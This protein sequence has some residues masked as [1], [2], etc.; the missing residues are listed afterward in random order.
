MR[1]VQFGPL[2]ELP[3]Q[4]R[5]LL[6]Q[7]NEPNATTGMPS[8]MEIIRASEFIRVGRRG[9]PDMKAS[10]RLLAELAEASRQRGIYRVLLDLREVQVGAV[11]A[12]TPVE[13]AS[14]IDTFRE[15]G[16]ASEQRVAVL[17][18]VDP[19]HGAR[20]FAFLSRQRGW[21]VKAF[22]NYEQAI[23]WLVYTTEPLPKAA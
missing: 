14:L 18:A 12:C 5:S 4:T 10:K 7:A 23:D 3:K 16:F 6:R 9:R 1:S 22:D 21:K 13:L 19:H 17:Y 8:E 20:L 2:L 15:L 11:P